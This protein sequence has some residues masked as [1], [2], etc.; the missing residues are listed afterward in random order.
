MKSIG[1][2]HEKC[3]LFMKSAGGFYEKCTSHERHRCFH[4]ELHE[5]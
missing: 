5:L 4:Y 3:M 2:F 1:G